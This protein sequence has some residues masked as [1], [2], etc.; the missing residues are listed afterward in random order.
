VEQQ[1]KPEQAGPATL[2]R[3][4]T[5]DQKAELRTGT[6]IRNML[7]TDG[8]K[9]YSKILETH[10]QGKRN[11]WETPA[12]TSQDGIS[13]VLRAE[14]AKGAIMALRLALSIPESVLSNDKVL[15]KSLGLSS[16]GDPE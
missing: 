12:E 5:P 6:A 8:W 11:E 3:E 9:V 7:M 10:L 4:L 15:R 13:Q 14:S 2:P 16:S 1:E